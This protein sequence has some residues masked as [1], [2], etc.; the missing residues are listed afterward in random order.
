MVGVSATFGALAALFL[1]VVIISMIHLSYYSM[2]SETDEPA[3]EDST[4]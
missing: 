4:T 1:V 2:Q 3:V